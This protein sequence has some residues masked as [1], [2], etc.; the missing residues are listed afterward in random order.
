MDPAEA[1]ENLQGMGFSLA[2]CERALRVSDNSLE[3]CDC[4]SNT[5]ESKNSIVNLFH[6]NNANPLSLIV[7]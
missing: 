4:R 3:R 1:L 2:A 7:A 5:K 6:R